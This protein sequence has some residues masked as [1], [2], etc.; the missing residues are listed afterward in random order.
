MLA[1]GTLFQ[2]H[3]DWLLIIYFQAHNVLTILLIRKT[4]KKNYG[5]HKLVVLSK[6]EPGVLFPL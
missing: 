3:L 4:I 1:H 6:C 2:I 5:F